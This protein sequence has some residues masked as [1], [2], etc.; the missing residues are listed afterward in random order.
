MIP[1]YQPF[2]GGREKEYVNQCLDSTWIS[3]R[4]E[5]ISR[6]ESEFARY[7]GAEHA[8]TVSNGTV[9]L[10][11]AMAALGLG[12]GDEVI[13]PTLTYVA[14]V[15]TIMQTGAS[16]VYAESLAD[17][18]NVSVPDIRSR[19]TAK[20]KAIMVVHLYGL[21]C[22]MDEV[23]ALCKEYN[24]LLI[25]D[26]AEAFGSLYKG[27]HVGTFGD[28]ATFSF[29]GNKT[30]TTGEGGMVVSR[31]KVV[32]EKACHLKSQGV[33]KTREYWHDELAFNYRMTN[34]CAAIGLAQLERADEI[35]LL[36][37]QV[38]DW[39]RE[40]LEGL[41]LQMHAEQPGTRHSYW[42]CSVLLDDPEQRQGLRDHLKSNGIE[43]RPLFAPAHNMPHCK[44]DEVFPVAQDLSTRGMNLPSYPTLTREQVQ[45]VAEEIR[46]YFAN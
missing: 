20:T 28:V 31:D 12:V 44:T 32:H 4:G 41:P 30:I 38:A 37:R 1:V 36:K 23:V 11:L 10:H 2:L 35:I 6:F 8:T 43:T 7:I 25:E 26:C 27:Q 42:M 24:L 13:V 40:A 19:I 16:V 14:S 45:Q 39:Y 9:A 17:T 18:W 29:F 15:N 3:S 46:R 5:F 21:A 33:S 22:D 34:I